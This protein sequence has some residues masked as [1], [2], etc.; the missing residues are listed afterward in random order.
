MIEREIKSL[1]NIGNFHKPRANTKG[2]T[3]PVS[4]RRNLFAALTDIGIVISNCYL[5]LTRYFYLTGDMP[6][7][8]RMCARMPGLDIISQWSG[9][10]RSYWAD[11]LFSSCHSVEI[12]CHRY[13]FIVLGLHLKDYIFADGASATTFQPIGPISLESFKSH[14]NID[15][16]I[17]LC[18]EL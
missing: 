17:D 1:K 9:Q 2:N 10:S 6:D 3:I 8:P 5:G 14:G 13:N 11:R 16:K 12:H 18:E 15:G 7:M 4:R